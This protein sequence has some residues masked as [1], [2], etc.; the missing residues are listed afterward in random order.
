MFEIAPYRRRRPVTP[1]ELAGGLV[2]LSAEA[3]RARHDLRA[4]AELAATAMGLVADVS[5]YEQHAG[6][7]VPAALRR[8]QFLGDVLTAAC[9]DVI[10]EFDS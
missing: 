7:D 10:A 5:A 4:K 1:K 6:H 8:L 2:R 3:E 9:A